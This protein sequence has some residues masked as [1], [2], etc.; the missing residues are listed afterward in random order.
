MRK[1]PAFAFLSM[2]SFTLS[3]GGVPEN[4]AFEK[5]LEK[6]GYVPKEEVNKESGES[7]ARNEEV[8]EP[9]ARNESILVIHACLCTP[10]P[11]PNLRFLIARWE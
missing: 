4:K 6:N 3:C 11:I 5:A 2:I 9:E 10:C 7:E 8:V 1:I